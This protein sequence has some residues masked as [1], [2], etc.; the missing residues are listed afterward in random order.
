M[1]YNLNMFE[2]SKLIGNKLPHVTPTSVR[3]YPYKLG[4]IPNFQNV[5]L[6]EKGA[7]H[8]LGDHGMWSHEIAIETSWVHGFMKPH[9]DYG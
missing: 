1:S 6:S 4:T 5:G 3:L 7:Y 2:I 9:Y 8:I